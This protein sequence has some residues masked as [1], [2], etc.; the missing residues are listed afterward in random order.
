MENTEEL[1]KKFEEGMD[2]I[3]L[4][5]GGD[6]VET[7]YVRSSEN[8]RYLFV[9]IERQ[10]QAFN[11]A[12]SILNT[13]TAKAQQTLSWVEDGLRSMSRSKHNMVPVAIRSTDVIV[14]AED[15]FKGFNTVQHKTIDTPS[16]AVAE[17]LLNG[18]EPLRKA[19][20]A[21]SY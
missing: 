10:W 12:V 14:T 4:A 8:G 20:L 3:Y 7:R 21:R 19:L 2:A 5:D 13:E 11:L 6:L 9:A 16:F 17:M 18:I 1:R 15:Y